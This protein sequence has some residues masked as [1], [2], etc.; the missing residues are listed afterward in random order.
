VQEAN[1]LAITTSAPWAP[2]QL[3]RA[4]TRDAGNHNAT[5]RSGDLA[6]RN[7]VADAWGYA[8]AWER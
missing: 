4:S 6:G 1:A 2:A 7:A 3:T 5:M 8:P